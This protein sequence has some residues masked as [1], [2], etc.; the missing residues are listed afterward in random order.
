MAVGNF[1]QRAPSP[2]WLLRAAR[3]SC[4]ATAIAMREVSQKIVARDFNALCRRWLTS[5]RTDESDRGMKQ[6]SPNF[7]KPCHRCSL[8]R[9]RDS[10]SFLPDFNRA[11]RGTTIAF[12]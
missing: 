7:A 2:S 9:R 4:T 10:I 12:S 6:S 1:T 3:A 8:P 5:A 11:G